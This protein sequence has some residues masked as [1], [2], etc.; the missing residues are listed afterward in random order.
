MNKTFND[1]L[2]LLGV[3]ILLIG[4]GYFLA[5]GRFF[6]SI[7][8]WALFRIVIFILILEKDYD[9]PRKI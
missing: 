7:V 6:E 4:T 3:I 5:H 2:D 1:L 8:F 9:L